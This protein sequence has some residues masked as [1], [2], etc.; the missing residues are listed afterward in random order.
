MGLAANGT[1][2]V[3]G[4]SDGSTTQRDLYWAVPAP[5][6]D[7]DNLGEWKRLDQTDLPEPGVSRAAIGLSGP[8]LFLV[9]GIAGDQPMNRALR[10]N[11]APEE[12]FFQLGLVGMVVPALRIEGE[13]GQQLGYLNAAGVGGAMFA[14]LLVIGY[15]F[16]HREQT[17]RA[18]DRV[19][20]RGR[21]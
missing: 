2:Y 7:G 4:G 13:I 10:A 19:R 12:P 5:G 9:G 17:R 3:A 11:T 8:N 16:A 14:L 20:R 18:W 15:L 1:I 6:A 21:A